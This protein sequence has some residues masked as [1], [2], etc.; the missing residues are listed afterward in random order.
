[1]GS[2]TLLLVA[3]DNDIRYIFLNTLHKVKR[4]L[5]LAKFFG[6]ADPPS[7][8]DSPR[9]QSRKRRT[10]IPVKL[11]PGGLSRFGYHTDKT[12]RARHNALLRAAR[13]EGFAPIIQRLNL[14]AT[15]TKNS[16]PENSRIFRKDQEWLSDYYAAVKERSGSSRSRSRSS[17]SSAGSEY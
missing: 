17:S 14:T 16:Q 10:I 9:R 7:Q 2:I 8:Q 5:A 4:M 11:K 3:T 13:E 12:E 6:F 1:M 15:F